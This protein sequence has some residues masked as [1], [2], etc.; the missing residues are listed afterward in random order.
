MFVPRSYLPTTISPLSRLSMDLSL[1]FSLFSCSI[2]HL[3][4]LYPLPGLCGLPSLTSVSAP[5]SPSSYCPVTRGSLICSFEVLCFASVF[6]TICVCL[7]LLL[8]F[9]LGEQRRVV[10]GQPR[11]FSLT[12][13]WLLTH[14][15]RRSLQQRGA[16]QTAKALL[17]RHAERLRRGQAW[18]RGAHPRGGGLSH[19]VISEDER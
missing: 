6:L 13:P 14:F 18:H 2:I 8:A 5:E 10:S 11:P 9:L 7:F 16:S 3:S 1:Y 15:P 4:Q 12:S 17:H 19:R